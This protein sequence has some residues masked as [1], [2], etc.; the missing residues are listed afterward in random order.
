MKCHMCDE[1]LDDNTPFHW[2]G[3]L[4]YCEACWDRLGL[5]EGEEE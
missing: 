1:E 3:I 2:F 5:E 4:Y